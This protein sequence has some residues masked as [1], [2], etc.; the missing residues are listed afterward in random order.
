MLGRIDA[1]ERRLRFQ[2]RALAAAAAIAAGIAW[3]Q[4]APGEARATPSR[5]E[6]RARRIALVGADERTLAALEPGPA[7]GARLAFLTPDGRT[8]LALEVGADG[9]PSLAL[10]DAAGVR[11]VALSVAGDD[12]RVSVL[13]PGRTV[14]ALASDGIAP[15]LAISDAEG[16]DRAWLAVRLGSAVLQF[17]DAHGMARAGLTTF[18]DDSG[19]AVVSGTDKSKPGLVLLG[20]DRSVV[21]SAP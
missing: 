2:R 20:R 12:A 5:P 3:A 21:W 7:G 10:A 9:A 19:V 4:A 13:G 18:N 1:L 15:R 6:L 8:P 14:M 17:L 16:R 11:R